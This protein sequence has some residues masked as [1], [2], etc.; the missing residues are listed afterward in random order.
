ML[1]LFFFFLQ[2]AVKNVSTFLFFTSAGIDGLV[3]GK[4][5]QKKG[6]AFR[7]RRSRNVADLFP[8]KT[9]KG[10]HCLLEGEQVILLLQGGKKNILK[11]EKRVEE[12]DRA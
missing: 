6:H 4:K 5:A 1:F 12:G 7:E 10:S 8:P 9:H 3:C 2:V 11:A